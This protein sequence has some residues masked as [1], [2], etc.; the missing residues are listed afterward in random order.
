MIPKLEKDCSEEAVTNIVDRTSTAVMGKD[1]RKGKM[2]LHDEENDGPA[3]QDIC[4]SW[5]GQVFQVKYFLKVYLKHDGFFERG[6]GT[7]V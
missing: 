3:F 2:K 4:P 1:A 7:C 6:Q 5:M